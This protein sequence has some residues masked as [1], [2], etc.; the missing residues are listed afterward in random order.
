MKNSPEQWLSTRKLGPIEID[1]VTTVMLKI[2]DG[3]CKM[4]AQGKV[5][6]TALYDLLKDEAGFYLDG[7]THQLIHRFRSLQAGSGQPG[8]A[9]RM[10]VYETRLLAETRISRPVMKAFKA[11]LRRAG[12]IGDG[13]AV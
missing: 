13:V 11:R 5:V 4:S 7:Q 6:M 12:V 9:L 3:K 1:C 8:E 10:Q 2:L